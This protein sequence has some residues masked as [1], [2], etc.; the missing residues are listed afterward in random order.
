MCT[1]GNGLNSW[2]LR[3]VNFALYVPKRQE[4]H[5]HFLENLPKRFRGKQCL[6]PN[7]K[8]KKNKLISDRS[9]QISPICLNYTDH[10]RVS[11][12]VIG[13]TTAR[14]WSFLLGSPL[15]TRGVG[16]IFKPFEYSTMGSMHAIHGFQFGVS[17]RGAKRWSSGR[18]EKFDLDLPFFLWFEFQSTPP[19]D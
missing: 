18:L 12:R 16:R 17:W 7:V 4:V 15:I 8:K 19:Q 5:R 2:I 11:K 6:F 13:P 3:S 10:H 9:S 14:T 1:S